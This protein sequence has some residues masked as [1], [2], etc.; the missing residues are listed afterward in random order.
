MALLIV[1]TDRRMT[2][3]ETVVEHK[4]EPD[5]RPLTEGR[6]TLSWQGTRDVTV[7][8]LVNASVGASLR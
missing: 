7:P 4:L 1:R 3:V 6:V 2:D 5:S 8:Y